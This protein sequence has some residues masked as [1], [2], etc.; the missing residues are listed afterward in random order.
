MIFS[1]FFIVVVWK[2]EGQEHIFQAL[3]CFSL[4]ARS[5]LFIQF[6]NKGYPCLEYFFQQTLVLR[7]NLFANPIK[8]KWSPNK[9]RVSDKSNDLTDE[10]EFFSSENQH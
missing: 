1:F 9:F 3:K 10:I 4:A 7:K 6:L 8:L 2:E 5:Y